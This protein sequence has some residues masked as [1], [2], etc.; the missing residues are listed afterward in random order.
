M[1]ITSSQVRAFK[2]CRRL[3]ELQYIE[4]LKPKVTPEALQTGSSY[5]A[6]VEKILKG[7]TYEEDTIVGVMAEQFKVHILPKLPK[8][9]AVEK[10][11][12]VNISED[13]CL[14]GKLDGITE[15][16]TPVEHKTT[17]SVIDEAYIN[18]LQWDDQ[19]TNYL[20]A[21]SLLNNKLIT[22]AIYTVIRKP[23]IRLKQNETEEEYINRCREWY[24]ED[25][26]KKVATFPIVR[27]Q[28][29]LNEK[30]E[31]LIYISKE[32]NSCKKFYR[33]PSHCSIMGCQFSSICLSYVPEIGSIDF[34]KKDKK[35]EELGG[36]E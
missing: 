24:C 7:L 33:N 23:S 31:E 30:Q 36:G 28:E 27:S 15:D 29:D 2:S 14:I 22:K 4:Q 32:I 11:F 16:L 1:Q 18:K 3:Y 17:A 21:M 25:T 12:K 9:V 13:E 6:L 26:D 20:L 19:V 8:I 34:I 5:H 35:N 10:E